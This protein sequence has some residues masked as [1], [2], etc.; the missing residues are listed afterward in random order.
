MNIDAKIQYVA[1]FV[2][3][4]YECVD[5]YGRMTPQSEEQEMLL[6]AIVARYDYIRTQLVAGRC[7]SKHSFN[8]LIGLMNDIHVYENQLQEL[9]SVTG[10]TSEMSIDELSTHN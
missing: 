7:C 2:S 5:K 1:Q 9:I 4:I 8:H 10:N 6:G 3:T